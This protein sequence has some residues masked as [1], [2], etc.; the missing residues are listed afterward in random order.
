MRPTNIAVIGSGIA[1]LSAAWLLSQRH[2][3]TL[4]E[5]D[6]RLG[7]HSNTFDTPKTPSSGPVPV[8][9]GFI[10]FN[11]QSY[12]NLVALFEHLGVETARSDM[13]F[14][15]SQDGGAYE[16]SGTGFRGIFGQG[17]NLLRPSH[18]RML[19]DI[20]R[21]FAA[22]RA[23]HA[24]PNPTQQSLGDYLTSN[25]YSQ[26]FIDRHIL[27]MAAAI[28]SCPGDSIL[29]F[30]VI[31]F[32]RFFANHG[33]LQVKNRPEWRTVKGGSRVYVDRIRQDIRGTVVPNRP[34]VSVKRDPD[35]VT[36]VDV[37]GKSDRFDACVIAAHADDALAMLADADARERELLSAFTYQPNRAILHTDTSLMPKRRQ[38]W[39]SWNYVSGGSRQSGPSSPPCVTYWMNRLQ[40]LPTN[41]QYFVT[42]NPSH[43]VR[44]ENQIASFDYAHPVFDQRAM[45]AQTQLWDIQGRRRTWFCGSYFGYGFHEDGLQA[46]LAAAED[47]G[48]VRRPWTVANESGRIHITASPVLRSRNALAVE[49]AQ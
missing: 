3:V 8:D 13:S 4:F 31:S 48:G 37:H 18:L 35:G 1:G 24:A 43:P 6:D 27:P 21:F 9:T 42:L 49:V 11:T 29:R 2:H 34:V 39:A 15:F 12:P 47:I 44:A 17:A 40:P 33:L 46:G 30:P 23:L 25:G 38:I 10:V 16:Y 19:L 7:G 32:A 45:T 20:K 22:A 14:A 28:W 41:D 26:A 36:I 5:R